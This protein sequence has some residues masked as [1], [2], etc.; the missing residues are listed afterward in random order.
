MGE[1]RG[2]SNLLNPSRPSGDVQ[3][4]YVHGRPVSVYE[5]NGRLYH[6]WKRGTYPYPM[7]EKERSR[8]DMLYHLIHGIILNHTGTAIE[9][10][11][12]QYV[13]A[14]A[15]PIVPSQTPP[16]SILDLGCGTGI[17]ASDMARRYPDAEIVGLDIV[18]G[19]PVEGRNL[20]WRTPDTSPNSAFDFEAPDWGFAGNSFDLIH[21]AQLCGAIS[22]WPRF[23]EKIK[24]YLRPKTGQVELFEIDLAPRCEDGTLSPDSPINKWWQL[25]Q[26]ATSNKPIACPDAKRMLEAAGFVDVV[27]HEY[28]LPFCDTWLDRRHKRERAVGSW[29]K[30]ITNEENTAFDPV[31]MINGLTMGPLTRN[32]GWSRAQVDNLV[33]DVLDVI[34]DDN[35]HA[36]HVL[37]IWTARRPGSDENL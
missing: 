28:P 19:Q 29:Y 24:R 14:V 35:I 12:S 33:A 31:S 30:V 32:L 1:P 3:Q 20:T 15:R 13:Q 4:H 22:S 23:F 17:W 34:K 11:G 10:E 8:Y 7:D 6:A 27:E 36:F 37:H 25:M 2:F 16:Y 5:E 21:A 26:E 18:G 9:N